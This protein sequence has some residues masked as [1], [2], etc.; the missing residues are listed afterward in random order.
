LLTSKICRGHASKCIQTARTF[1]PGPQR[2]MF[3]DMAKRW[4][5]LAVNIESSAA[6]LDPKSPANDPGEP[7]RFGSKIEKATTS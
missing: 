1:V 6:L 3:L 5:D 4:V 7:Y 2:E